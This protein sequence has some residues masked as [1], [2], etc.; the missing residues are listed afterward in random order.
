MCLCLYVGVYGSTFMTKRLT[1]F[2][3]SSQIDISVQVLQ[4]DGGMVRICFLLKVLY[5]V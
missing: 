3:C 5:A 1:L 4:A 2:S